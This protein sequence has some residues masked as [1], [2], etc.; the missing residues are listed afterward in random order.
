LLNR[1]LRI[2]KPVLFVIIALVVILALLLSGCSRLQGTSKNQAVFD[3]SHK[4][5]FS[6][7]SEKE[8]G[9]SSFS[10]SL[11]E[12]GYKL[13]MNEQPLATQSLRDA[14]LLILAGPMTEFAQ[15]EQQAI[16]D[17]IKNGG[18]LLV[19]IHISQPVIS[20]T[21]NFDIQPSVSTVCDPANPVENSP[22]DFYVTDFADHPL[23]SNIDKLA[24]FGTWALRTRDG[25]SANIVART[26]DKAWADLNQDRLLGQDEP[27]ESYGIVAVSGFGEGKVVVCADDA[28]LINKFLEAGDNKRFEEN[29]ISWFENKA[30]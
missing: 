8:M 12:H 18:N 21:E 27:Q 23:G 29:L 28:I 24:V 20:L 9:L 1:S 13:K 19:L 26:S 17:F 15:E 14:K 2:G 3:L 30:I 16:S 10:K 4:E 25:G 5:I 6:P 11:S 7:T 22:Q